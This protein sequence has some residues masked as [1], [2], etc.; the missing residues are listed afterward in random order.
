VLLLVPPGFAAAVAAA[1]AVTKACCLVW[2]YLIMNQNADASKFELYL[3]WDS[4]FG[5][6]QKRPRKERADFPR[7]DFANAP[8]QLMLDSGDY[9]I[10]T[11]KQGRNFRRKFRLPAPLF[12]FVVATVLHRR[13]F[14]EYDAKG[15]GKDAFGRPIPSLQVKCLVVFRLLGSG[16]EFAAVYDGSKVDEQ[17]AR[18]FFYRFNRIF[19]HSLYSIWVH[20]PSTEQEVNEALAIYKRLGLPG[21]IGSTD[22]FHLF[23]DRCPAQ[24]KVDCR[25]GRYKR[26]T[27]VWSVSNDHHRKIYSIT[28]PF[29]GCTSDKTIQQYDGF[30]QSVHMKTEPLF[31]NVRY[32][33]YDANGCPQAREGAWILCDNGYHKWECMQMPPSFCT[34]Q[35]EVVFREVLESSRKPT[36]CL[37]GILKQRFWMLKNPL[38]FHSKTDITNLMYTCAV[39][40]NMLL[41]YDGFDKLWTADDWITLDPVPSDDENEDEDGNKAKMRRLIPPERLQE[42]V[43]PTADCGIPTVTE[44]GHLE[45]RAALITNLKHLWDKGEVEHLRYPQSTR[46]RTRK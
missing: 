32:T 14:P 13:F 4:M 43:L 16:C 30:L 23:W 46:S 21:A 45:L 2:S 29:F 42:Y 28:D 12:D 7:E 3:A 33:L 10:E 34:T 11:T 27:M 22:C 37:I 39:L 1:A 24:L 17:T 18:N 25:N 44:S 8:W 31:A 20:P 35:D 15:S 36:E 9:R 38:R 26:C 19:A 5:K 41:H 40:H 6:A